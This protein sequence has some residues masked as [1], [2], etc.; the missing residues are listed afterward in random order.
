MHDDR[1]A[2]RDDAERD[3]RS[4]TRHPPKFDARSR[5]DGITTAGGPP[6]TAALGI[7]V[8]VLL[9]WRT[10]R[11]GPALVI[12]AT[13]A[14]AHFTSEAPNRKWVTDFTYS[15]TWAGFVYVA[16]VIDCF[17]R[18]IVGWHASTVKD[19]TMVTT[20]LKM[21]LWRRDHGGHR[22]GPGLIHHSDAGSQGGFNPSSQHRVVGPSIT[23]LQA[24]PLVFSTRVSSEADR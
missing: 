16:F 19:T 8:A 6:E 11:Y 18:A 5:G 24:L 9:I 3:R 20:A 22:V 17:S 4:R 15:R 1:R 23:A 12:L 2:Q 14:A 21:A 7:V 13:V 10:K